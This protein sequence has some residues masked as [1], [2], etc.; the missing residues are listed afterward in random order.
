MADANSTKLHLNTIDETGNTY[1]RLR[2]LGWERKRNKV[3]WVCLCA[4]GRKTSVWG[5]HLRNGSIK[6]CGKSGCHG[7]RRHGHT[8]GPASALC[9]PEY[10]TWADMIQR[11]RNPQCRGYDRYGGR[12]VEVCERWANSFAAFLEDMGPRP[13]R[14]H[15]IDRENNDGNYEPGNCRWATRRE[16]SLNTRRAISITHNG[17]SRSLLDWAEHLGVDYNILYARIY[18]GWRVA[19]AI[20]TPVGVRIRRNSLKTLTNQAV[21][22]TLRNC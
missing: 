5:A 13:S 8:A 18:R 17:E 11:C 10:R 9:S 3:Y 12:G 22:R 1:G 20:S 16:Q 2:V 14:L 19:K 7:S 6:S 4:C 15:S 21:S